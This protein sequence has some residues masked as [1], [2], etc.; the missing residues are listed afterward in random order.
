M[1]KHDNLDDHHNAINKDEEPAS[2]VIAAGGDS[3][4]AGVEFHTVYVGCVTLSMIVIINMN[5]D[6]DYDDCDEE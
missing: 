2:G 1:N 6:H 3:I 5:D 4:T